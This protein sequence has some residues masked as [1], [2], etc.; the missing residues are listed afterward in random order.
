MA[1]RLLELFDAPDLRTRLGVRVREKVLER[2]D[3]GVVMPLI[4]DVIRRMADTT[5]DTGVQDVHRGDGL[6]TALRHG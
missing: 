5:R 1:D 4:V 6:L 3:A 2:N